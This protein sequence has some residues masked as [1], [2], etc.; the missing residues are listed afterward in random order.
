[1]ASD[2]KKD[3]NTCLEEKS[4]LLRQSVAGIVI[5]II[6]HCLTKKGGTGQIT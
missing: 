3:Y 2:Y 1:M 4:G 5:K 6:M